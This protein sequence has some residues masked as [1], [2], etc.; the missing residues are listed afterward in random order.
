MYIHQ[1]ASTI[2]LY[3][4][5]VPTAV[6]VYEA[7]GESLTSQYVQVTSEHGQ[8]APVISCSSD[9]SPAP[10]LVWVGQNGDRTLPEGVTASSDGGALTLMW[11]RELSVTDSGRYLC[12]SSNLVGSSVA[13]MELFVTS[14][15]LHTCIVT[16]VHTQSI[17]VGGK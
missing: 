15:L 3:F 6:I 4:T 16:Q 2:L 7:E 11:N 1:N 12:N 13:T 5:D 14:K 17:I 10:S 8:V 9:G